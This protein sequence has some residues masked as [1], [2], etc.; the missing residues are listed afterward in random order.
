MNK[1]YQVAGKAL[2]SEVVLTLI[3]ENSDVADDTFKVLWEKITHFEAQ[4]SRFQP[5]SELSL[6]NQKSGSWQ[7]VSS[8]F[9]SILHCTQIFS[10]ETTGLYNPFILPALQQAGYQGSWPHT[11][12]VILSTDYTNRHIFPPNA[13]KIENGEVYIPEGAAL[14]LGGIGKGFLL[15]LL[16]TYLEGTIENYWLS[17]GGDILCKGTDINNA[18]W[19]INV[20]NAQGEILPF[21]IINTNKK[22]FGIATSGVTKRKGKHNN[23][24]WHHIIDPKTGLPSETD[25]SIAT[26]CAPSAVAADIHAKCLVIRGSSQAEKYLKQHAIQS[27]LLQIKTN[28][29]SQQIFAYG[30]DIVK[31]I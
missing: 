25:V 29:P 30:P 28:D 16:G 18:P 8:E 3:T 27:A 13:L 15:D 24:A 5:T 22:S 7:K 21:Q 17:L 26:V 10:Q 9:L 4:F 23:K 6:F 19:A 11:S 12:E 1:R 20:Q 2:G 31:K 14:D